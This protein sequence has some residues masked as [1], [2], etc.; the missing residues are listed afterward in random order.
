MIP[1]YTRHAVPFPTSSIY[2]KGFVCLLLLVSLSQLG[3][4][5]KIATVTPAQ[6]SAETLTPSLIPLRVWIAAPIGDQ[7][8]WLRQWVAHSEQ[9]LELRSLTID[10]LLQRPQCDCDVLLYP[11]Q[12]IG[13]LVERD[14][15]VK[16]PD[17]SS[18]VSTE[19][20]SEDSL[21]NKSASLPMAWR[22]Q[23]QYAGQSL[24][25][26]MGCVLPVFIASESFPS[27]NQ[28]LTW[29]NVRQ[30]LDLQEDAPPAFDFDS[31]QVDRAALVARFLSI[32]ATL[33]N[34]DPS[35][36]LLF[37]L[38]TMQSRLG[39]EN[40]QRAAR[41]L[42]G[43]AAQPMGLDSV[44]GSHSTAWNW[45]AGN[46]QPTLAIAAPAL[47]D[48]AAIE[49]TTGQIVQF[50]ATTSSSQR[51][52]VVAW[53][54]GA[55]LMA[56]LSSQC[57]QSNQATAVLR[58][59]AEPGTRTILSKF[60]AGIESPTTAAGS[61]SLAW[62]ARQTLSEVVSGTGVAQEPRLPGA[63]EYR[64][65]L[66]D[67]LIEFL[68]GRKTAKQALQATHARWQKVTEKVGPAQRQYYEKSLGLTL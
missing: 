24:A 14:W 68:A 13:E 5:R 61:D 2:S 3:C 50:Q 27:N 11:A 26:P 15:I 28:P 21:E 63:I 64:D 58:W 6:P 32:A 31:K 60:A 65:A 66:A 16:A 44:I 10:E 30:A 20:S 55:G 42:A 47:I 36:G 54:S 8:I 29:D 38:Q 51:P 40:F 56:S 48:S 46:A 37:D 23:A 34:R 25:V 41:L 19:A 52:T 39:E 17:K 18:A 9:P 59:L 49:I 4:E 67:E 33:S 7:Q 1:R 62:E 43:L 53:N 45:S 57:R 22:Q 12:L 35:Y